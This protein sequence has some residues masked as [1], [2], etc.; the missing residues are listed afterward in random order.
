M[1]A[2]AIEPRV[3][4]CVLDFYVL[5]VEGDLLAGDEAVEYVPVLLVQRVPLVVVEPD[6]VLS[7]DRVLRVDHIE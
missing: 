5:A 1:V 2:A 4:Q 7:P 6:A 3:R